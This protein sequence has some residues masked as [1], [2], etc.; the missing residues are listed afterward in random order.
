MLQI[1]HKTASK[2]EHKINNNANVDS[3]VYLWKTPMY[4][5]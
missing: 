3:F 4:S 1:K 5:F 2:W